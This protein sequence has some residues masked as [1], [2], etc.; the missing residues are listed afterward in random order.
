MARKTR[1]TK[2]EGEHPPALP[3]PAPVSVEEAGRLHE[4]AVTYC[5]Q[6]GAKALAK[7]AYREAVRYWEQALQALGH[8]P[9]SRPLL[10]QAIDLRC[11]VVVAL[12]PIA[13]R[14]QTLTYLRE[15]EPLAERLGDPRRLGRVYRRLANALRQMQHY[16]PALA[17][18]QRTHAIATTLPD[19]HLQ[20]M[21]HLEMGM[22]Y[23]DLGDYRQALS[24]LQQ[25][26]TILH[27]APRSTQSFEPIDRGPV[28][29]RVYLVWCL[30]EL[31]AFADGVRYGE[32]A[33][34]IAEGVDRPY[35]R[36]SSTLRVGY[37]HLR[38]GTL[39]Q[40]MPLLERAV[41]LGQEADL[42]L[43]GRN[44][45]AYLALTY[46][47][48][49]RATDA[50]SLLGQIEGNPAVRPIVRGEASLL[51]G[52]VEEAH[53]LAQRGL[54]NAQEHTSRGE[55]ARALWLLGAIAMRRDPSDM[56][57]AETAYLQ[58]LTLAEELGMRPLQA[59]C[60][61]GLGTMYAA[62]GQQEQARAALSSAVAMYQS[63]AMRL[64]LP[65]TETARAQVERAH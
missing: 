65:Q 9:P 18:G 38:Q 42:L 21:A 40:A 55:E 56:A 64:W 3:S 11:D 33:L 45:A 31:G 47:L 22:I 15:T 19:M 46:A 34:Q 26:L 4:R 49:G 51:V 32:E 43:L 1:S 54:A 17:Y 27:N 41:A 14:E 6:T 39:H 13:P 57:S 12:A 35:E 59:H 53:R 30:S 50:L 16:G 10:E 48:A 20:R 58:A 60:H 52:A 28:Q 24:Q 29:A 37:L 61:R 23:T 36:L 8:L 63:M 44:A 5:Q 25:V 7:S 62:T 2:R